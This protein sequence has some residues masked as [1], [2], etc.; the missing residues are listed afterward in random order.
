MRHYGEVAKIAPDPLL[1]AMMD[2][3]LKKGLDM[4]E[5]GAKYI[6]YA[7]LVTGIANC[8]D[9]L[10]AIRK[11]VFEEGQITLG[12]LVEATRQNFEGREPLRQMLMNRAPKYGN[13]IERV[14]A[15][16]ER[17]LRDIVARR[18]Y[19][20]E[21]YPRFRFPVGIGTFESYARF[22]NRVGASADGRLSQETLSSNYSPSVGMDRSGPT[23]AIRSS[24]FPP[25]VLKYVCGCPLDLQIN[26][27]EAAGDS[28][29]ERLQALIRSFL[30]LNGNILTIT[31]VS[32]ELLRDAQKHPERHRG[33]RVRLG[34]L[35]AYFVALPPKHQAIMIERVKHGV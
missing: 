17:V 11:L 33:L 5:G 2:D 26:S 12:E 28:G 29:V 18:D 7:P 35:S 32:E 31:G 24:V 10:E 23:A 19:W 9:S 1:S 25:S 6:F 3:C 27:N 30:D 4:T 22:G 21:R 8:V 20:Q 34:G 16:V 13:D 15:L 14:D